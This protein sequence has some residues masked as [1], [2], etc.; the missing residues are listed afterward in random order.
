M[1]EPILAMPDSED[2]A[3]PRPRGAVPAFLLSLLTT[4]LGHLY[5]GQPAKALDAL[6]P[7]VEAFRIP[8]SAMEPTLLIGDYLYVGKTRAIWWRT[9]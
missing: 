6:E 2:M 7:R 4:G 5:A 8:S 3:A 1:T 9:S